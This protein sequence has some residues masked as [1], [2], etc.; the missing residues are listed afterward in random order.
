MIFYNSLRDACMLY[1]LLRWQ[2]DC[3]H[4]EYSS[5]RMFGNRVPHMLDND[6]TPYSAVDI[7]VKDLVWMNDL[8][9]ADVVSYHQYIIILASCLSQGIVSCESS[10]SRIPVHVSSIAHQ[11]FI[12][13]YFF[14]KKTKN[15]FHSVP[16]GDHFNVEFFYMKNILSNGVV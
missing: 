14:C 2:C 3:L 15:S 6:Y 10:N 13:G 1:N 8:L 9:F 4:N 5:C 7:F 16:N 12:S 11:L